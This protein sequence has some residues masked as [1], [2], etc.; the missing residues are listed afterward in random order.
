M[1]TSVCFEEEATTRAAKDSINNFRR[2]RAASLCSGSFVWTLVINCVKCA[3][4]QTFCL[5]AF[6]AQWTPEKKHD[7]RAA[8]EVVF[9]KHISHGVR[10][11]RALLSRPRSF[12]LNV[13]R[14]A[15]LF[16]MCTGASLFGFRGMICRHRGLSDAHRADVQEIEKDPAWQ[17]TGTSSQFDLGTLHTF[18]I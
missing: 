17:G 5:V 13:R 11:L 7:K 2:S 8:R 12:S 3:G 4:R 14:G 9:V 1:S 18:G 6:H 10:R 16:Q 15:P